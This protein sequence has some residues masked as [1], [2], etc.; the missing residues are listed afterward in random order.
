MME[1]ASQGGEER[2]QGRGVRREGYRDRDREGGCEA[3]VCRWAGRVGAGLD[4]ESFG[5]ELAWV[6]AYGH[7]VCVWREG[8][9]L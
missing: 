5:E 6:E 7:K 4:V 2:V 1:S 8:E 3:R 9:I